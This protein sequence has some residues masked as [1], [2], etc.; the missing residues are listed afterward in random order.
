MNA[1]EPGERLA[2]PGGPGKEIIIHGINDICRLLI[3]HSDGSEVELDLRPND[4]VRLMVGLQGPP[5]VVLLPAREKLG[6]LR[7]VE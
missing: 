1:D 3:T 2:I 6:R 4:Q 7:V 5:T